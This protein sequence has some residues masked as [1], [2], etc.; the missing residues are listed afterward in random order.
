M[1]AAT[2]PGKPKKPRRWTRRRFLK[3]SATGGGVLVLGFVVAPVVG[4]YRRQGAIEAH[5]DATG[6]FQPNAWLTI[7]PDDRIVFTL[8]RVEMGQGTMTS[9]P[10][11]IAEELEVDPATIDV[12][13]AIADRRYDHPE[14]FLQVTGGSSSVRTSWERLRQAG[15]VARDMLR[16]AA[17]ETWDVPIEACVAHDGT[18]MHEPTGRRATYGSLTR[19]AARQSIPDPVLKSP[20]DFKILGQSLNRVDVPLKVDG[21][22]GFG[23]DV[24][25]P[26][27]AT[28]VIVRPPVLGATVKAFDGRTATQKPGVRA[29]VD[30]PA[31]VA[32][33]A[34]TYWQARAAADAV[35]VEWE[36]GNPTLDSVKL[37]EELRALTD[38]PG[39]AVRDDGD[40]D[41]ALASAGRTVDAAYEVPHLAHAPMEPQNC[42]A[43]VDG[44]RCEVWAPTQSPGVARDIVAT[45]LDIPLDHVTVHT[46]FLGGGF[47][48]RLVSDFVVE[49][50]LLLHK[51]NQPVKV[52]W[53]REDDMCHSFLRPHVRHV[54]QASIGETRVPVAWRHRIAAPTILGAVMPEWLPAMTPGAVPRAVDRGLSRMVG[55]V[56]GDA[57]VTD[58]T[59]SEGASDTAYAID[60]LRVEV[61]LH[62]PGVPVGFWRSVGHSHTA[63]AVESFIDELALAASQDPYAFRRELLRNAPRHRGVLDAAAARAGWDTPSPPGI[64]RG[65]AQH[66][67][68]ET[69]VAQVA[70]VSVEDGR[71]RVHRVVCAVDCGRVIN[72]DIVRAQ[73]EG[74]IA[75][76]LSAALKQ[77][78]SYKDGHV[79]QD[80]FHN[81]QMLRMN[82]M[83]EVEVVIVESEADPTGVGEPAV[84]PIAPA[85]AN[86]LAA[87][88][89]R[90]IRT[91]PIEP[92]WARGIV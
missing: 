73:M 72:P 36:G 83:P 11:L 6:E 37:S 15:A 17:A 79:E 27:M 56:L 2:T 40:A 18:V 7:H 84:P 53:S 29:V 33:V 20:A 16:A 9:H 8:D 31:G 10:M 67:S 13:F 46:T 91:L 80:N 86:A 38:A 57:W 4:R 12:E 44:D 47:G 48:R 45:A 62:D 25:V 88:T 5:A 92:E 49:A 42:T 81:Y 64:G 76:G 51:I 89:G 19:T 54:L 78:I 85:V 26:D 71:I 77:R 28:A 39:T 69:Y 3:V 65:I 60:N 82:E 70:E 23:I 61:A 66:F 58:P 63:F 30:I 21:S 75:F 41:T 50:A 90:R 14:F 22:A 55:G 68:F 24:R 1:S 35:T 74:S 52:M 32:V 87:A 34:D 59:S 43:H